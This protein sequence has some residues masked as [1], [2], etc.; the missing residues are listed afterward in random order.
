MARLPWALPEPTWFPKKLI[1]MG[2]HGE[3]F[4]QRWHGQDERGESPETK[5]SD[6]WGKAVLSRER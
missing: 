1:R 3:S 4:R 5:T 6:S 2:G